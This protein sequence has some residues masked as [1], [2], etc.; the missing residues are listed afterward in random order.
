[1]AEAFAQG[2][3]RFRAQYPFLTPSHLNF[4]GTDPAWPNT[5]NWPNNSVFGSTNSLNLSAAPGNVSG[6]NAK[7]N[8]SEW[9]DRASEEWFSKIWALSSC[10]SYNFRVYVVA[11]MVDSNKMPTGPVMKKYYH[12]YARNG[13]SV[14]PNGG[15]NYNSAGIT[16]W[17]PTVGVI[18]TYESPY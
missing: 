15:T 1:M 13:S 6:A 11:Q 14:N 10:Q 12:L 8:I 5:N 3:M 9:N 2:V 17:T 18:K 16:N 7:L 4:I